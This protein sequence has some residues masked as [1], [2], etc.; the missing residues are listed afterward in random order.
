MERKI[1]REIITG[2]TGMGKVKQVIITMHGEPSEE[3][4]NRLAKIMKK[5]YY[6]EKEY[7]DRGVDENND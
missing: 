1:K 5:I 6:Q 3:A 4:L 7:L 2:V